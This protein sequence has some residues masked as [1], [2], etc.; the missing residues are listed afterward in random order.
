M[1]K[2]R[3]TGRGPSRGELSRFCLLACLGV[4][5]TGCADNQESLIVL[6]APAWDEEGCVIAT[7]AD[8]ALPYGTLDLSFG[9][10]YAMPAVLLNNTADQATNDNNSGIVTNE[11]QLLDADVDLSMAQ[12]PEIID[13][14]RDMNGAF[15]SFNV[16]LSTNSILPG[17]TVGVLV[18]VIPQPTAVAMAELVRAQFGPASKLTVEASVVFHA[19][20]SGNNRGSVGGVDAREF[21]FP[22]SVCFDCL[23]S[24]A[25]CPGAECPVG[26][27][28]FTGGVCG[29]AQDLV[30]TPTAC[31]TDD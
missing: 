22:I 25:G 5:G 14:L 16:P 8:A 13:A 20:R 21:S 1:T 6:M 18:E 27:D 4:V 23:R 26:A 2:R 11:I 31:T 28:E 17:Q 19:S 15:V 3:Q 29:N 12:A 7:N 9:T 10:P 24:C 30:L